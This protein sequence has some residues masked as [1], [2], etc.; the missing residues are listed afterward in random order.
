MRAHKLVNQLTKRYNTTK[1]R[2]IRK[3]LQKAKQSLQDEYHQLDSQL[4]E[5]QIA[6]TESDLHSNNT[7]KA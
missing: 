6:E 7:G 5:Q 2:I 4:L 1:S 3:N